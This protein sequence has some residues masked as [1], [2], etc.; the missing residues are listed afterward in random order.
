MARAGEKK[1]TGLQWSEGQLSKEGPPGSPRIGT[2]RRKGPGLEGF[3]EAQEESFISMAQC[4]VQMCPLR[5]ESSRFLAQ[6]CPEPRLHAG[7]T[8][9]HLT[10]P[11]DQASY[12]VWSQKGSCCDPSVAELAG[13]K[14]VCISME[15]P[16]RQC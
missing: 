2:K 6:V 5:A 10:P 12:K 3:P 15:D 14:E 13:G 7:P 1:G 4:P 16:G 11:Q 8:Q 9:C